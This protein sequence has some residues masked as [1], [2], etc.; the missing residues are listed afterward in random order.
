MFLLVSLPVFVF[1]TI[2]LLFQSE[3]AHLELEE[4]P[5]QLSE[6]QSTSSQPGSPEH[7]KTPKLSSCSIMWIDFAADFKLIDTPKLSTN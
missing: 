3:S 1:L 6:V 2:C 5:E 7:C 4:V